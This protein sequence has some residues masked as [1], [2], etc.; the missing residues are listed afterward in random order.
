MTMLASM[1]TAPADPLMA[2]ACPDC[3]AA[4]SA[5]SAAWQSGQATA[6]KGSAGAVCMEASIVMRTASVGG[7][8]P[9]R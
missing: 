6:I 2:V 4:L 9:R 7:R 3:H 1:Q 5:E 8:P